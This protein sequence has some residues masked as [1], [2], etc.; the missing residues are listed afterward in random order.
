MPNISEMSGAP[1]RELHVFYV[2]D[3]SGSMEGRRIGTLNRAM[4]ETV[5]VLREQALKNADAQLKIAV[6][7][8][9]TTPHWLNP[10]GP[11]R[12]E[13]FIYESLTPGGLTE[14]GA[15]LEELGSKLS[16]EKFLKSMTGAYLPVIIFMTDGYATDDYTA[17]LKKIQKNRWFASSVKIGFAIGDDPDANM[18][19]KIVGNSEAVIQT[20]DLALFARLLKWASVTASMM[21]SRSRTSSDIIT[22]RDIIAQVTSNGNISASSVIPKTAVPVSPDVDPDDIWDDGDIWD[23]TAFD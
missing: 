13:D 11:E 12:M 20:E 21:C 1:R 2:L 10:V 6:L 8:F 16:R 22:G 23:D 15:A 17:A 5:A 4:T 18:I 9:N 14:V 19:A 3:T 7:E